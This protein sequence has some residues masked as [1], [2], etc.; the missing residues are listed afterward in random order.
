MDIMRLTLLCSFLLTTTLAFSQSANFEIT[1]YINGTT[2]IEDGLIEIGPEFKWDNAT[3]GKSYIARPYF[4][5]PLTDKEN[6]LLKIDRF[7]STWRG[8]LALSYTLDKTAET[9]PIVRHEFIGQ[10]EVGTSQFK[11]YLTGDKEDEST[12]SETSYGVE[13]KYVGYRT[14]GSTGASQWSPQFRVR[15]SYD[16]ESSDKVGVVLPANSNGVVATT[17]LVVEP[18]KVKPIFSPA[19]SLQIYPGTGNF[20]YSP[21]VYYDF[22]GEAGESN[23]FDGVQRLRMESWIFYYPTVE[24]TSNV[25][26]GLSP[27]LSLRTGGSDDFN[28]VEYG[29]MI[30]IR[31]G[32]TFLQF[33]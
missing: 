17:D 11:Y 5:L 4:R 15:Y 28:K 6:N 3:E 10:V 29:G 1:P 26:I 19:F 33:L 22:T 18:P 12:L 2:S 7:T 23:P 21:S 27:F 14:E 32:S 16:W 24:G 9:G 13:L 20:S 31:F 8:I 25:K 30:T